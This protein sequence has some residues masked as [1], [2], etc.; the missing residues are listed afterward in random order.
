MPDTKISD[1]PAVTD[2][3]SGD[4]Y[5]LARAGNS[6]SIDIDDLSAGISALVTGP[7]VLIQEIVAPSGGSATIDFTSIPGT[8]RHLELW[9]VARSEGAA[10]DIL[11]RFNNDSAAN[12]RLE[13]LRGSGSSASAATLSAQTAANI[14]SVPATGSGYDAHG[15]ILFPYYATG[16][17]NRLAVSSYGLYDGSN[18]QVGAFS[19]QWSSTSAVTRITLFI[20]GTDIKQGSIFSLYGIT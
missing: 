20:S 18:S 2:L 10:N 11:L 5:V 6:K 19:A 12:Y 7:M 15:K 16:A 14:A 1:L 13:V 9:F 17:F 4:Q 8:Y 3:V